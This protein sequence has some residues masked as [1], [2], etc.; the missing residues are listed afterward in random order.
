MRNDRNY[1]G[2]AAPIPGDRFR[3]FR[4]IA[5]EVGA[6]YACDMASL[7]AGRAGLHPSKLPFADFVRRP[8]D[9]GGPRRRA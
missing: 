7:A 8:Q 3:R 2:R 4:Q 1:R 9:P 6:L 5:D